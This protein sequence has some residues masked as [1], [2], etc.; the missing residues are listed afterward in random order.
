MTR[1]F[2]KLHLYKI[3]T[4]SAGYPFRGKIPEY[5]EGNL[6]VVQMKDSS[7][8]FG[9]D[10]MSCVR[11]EATGKKA[12]DWLQTGDILV[13]ARGNQNYA[14]L[15]DTR[16]APLPAVAAPH[17][18]VVRPQSDA[19][20]PEFLAWQLNQ[21]PCQRYFELHAEGT[22][23]KSIRRQVLEEALIGLPSLAEQQ[24]ILAMARTLQ[25][26]RQLMQRLQ[27][28]SEQMMHAIATRLLEPSD[29]DAS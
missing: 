4:I 11:S 2:V 20:I 15:V 16:H 19:L 5:P 27:H 10:W 25:E 7:S 28:N 17:F 21:Q 26:E 8:E 14:V 23:T 1:F 18:Y 29:A 22:L 12:P 3:A 13:A 9:V 24:T 6:A